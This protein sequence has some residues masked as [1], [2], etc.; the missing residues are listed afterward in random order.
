ME[1]QYTVNQV[2][3][4]FTGFEAQEVLDSV[5]EKESS[6]PRVLNFLVSTGHITEDER[7]RCLAALLN[8]QAVDEAEAE[9]EV[10]LLIQEQGLVAT[11]LN[12]DY[13][14]KKNWVC[15]GRNE[16]GVHYFLTSEPKQI[17]VEQYLLLEDVQSKVYISSASAIR[18][19]HQLIS[20]IEFRQNS[21]I[22]ELDANSLRALASEA[23]IVNLVNSII[24]KGVLKG[25][26]DIHI[27]PQKSEWKVRLRVDGLLTELETLP[28]NVALPVISRIKILSGMDIAEKRRP[29]DGKISTRAASKSLDIR[30]STLPVAGGENV[31]M[32]L[33]MKGS[34]SFDLTTLGFEQDLLEYI[35]K[36]LSQTAG[37][38]LLTGPTGSGKTTTLYSFIEKIK[39]PETKF[40][41]LEDPVEYKIEGISQMQVNSDIGFT[42]AAGLR[43]ILRQDPDVIMVGEI[44][45]AETAQ[46]ALQSSMT[47]HL[48]FSTVHT[49]DAPSAYSRLTDLGVEEFLLNE[50]I[51]GVIAQRLVR[52]LCNHCKAPHPESDT[53]LQSDDFAFLSARTDIEPQIYQPQGCAHCNG[54]GFAGRS[55]IS[56]YLPN[57]S[58]I[59][60]IKKD[61]QF[62]LKA[63][64]FMETQQL[65]SLKQD[66]YLKVAKGVTSVEEAIR[67][68]GL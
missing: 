30:V 57:S 46:I 38:I 16:Q 39:S 59:K 64:E 32:R 27:E 34:L 62:S 26:S 42:F 55:V 49:N 19:V 60:Q 6:E 25:A 24:T 28:E 47:G 12:L 13:L 29:Q 63:R 33:L 56:E 1:N 17:E 68:V 35:E 58:Q 10:N 15:I 22:G 2:L 21:T 50:A 45:D 53:L 20:E 52:K 65:R 9:A 43:S 8:H 54:S 36:D 48:V 41:T 11:E 40:I 14:F 7:S 44:R 5:L 37:V 23:P 61:D 67:V 51:L 31:V 4:Q 3:E 18:N 66:V